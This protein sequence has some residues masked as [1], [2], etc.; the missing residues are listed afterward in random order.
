[1]DD[2]VHGPLVALKY[3]LRIATHPA[4]HVFSIFPR[5]STH[6]QEFQAAERNKQHRMVVDYVLQTLSK[7]DQ[8]RISLTTN[9]RISNKLP[10]KIRTSAVAARLNN[11][12]CIY[13][14]SA[15]CSKHRAR[16][17]AKGSAQ[18]AA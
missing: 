13:L 15:I 17:D 4:S 8:V 11:L 16:K 18:S 7:F 2:T 10:N 14:F 1:M 5:S 12:E 6:D 3:D 9:D